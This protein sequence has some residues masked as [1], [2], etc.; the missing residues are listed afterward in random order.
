MRMDEPSPARMLDAGCDATTGVRPSPVAGRGSDLRAAPSPAP[1]FAKSQ[2]AIQA[3]TLDA[4][5]KLAHVA[6]KFI[7]SMVFA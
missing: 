6:F 2:R 3:I 1:A 5:E 7:W 4:A